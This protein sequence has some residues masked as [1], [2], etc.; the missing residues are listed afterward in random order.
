MAGR[1]PTAS[2]GPPWLRATSVGSVPR[3]APRVSGWTDDAAIRPAV[4]GPSAAAPP[5]PSVAR[6][7]NSAMVGAQAGPVPHDSPWPR[8]GPGRGVRHRDWPEDP[9]GSPIR[10]LH[11]SLD[12]RNVRP[13]STRSRPPSIPAGPGCRRARP[14]QR[15]AAHRR[16]GPSPGRAPPSNGQDQDHRPRGRTVPRRCRRC[17]PIADVA[18]HAAGDRSRS[19][20]DRGHCG[21]PRPSSAGSMP[22]CS[23]PS[24]ERSPRRRSALLG[25]GT[26]DR[27]PAP[28]SCSGKMAGPRRGF[29]PVPER[30]LRSPDRPS[31]TKTDPDRSGLQ[32]RHT[33]E[34]S[35]RGAARAGCRPELPPEELAQC[36]VERDAT[37][38]QKDDDQGKGGEREVEL[39]ARAR[40]SPR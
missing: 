20:I 31:P 30:P 38:A 16:V 22:R 10:P 21:P 29:Q 12:P 15:A 27:P 24:I 39:I 14:S 36:S 19:P 26:P 6:Q 25:G 33:S 34:R 37:R 13:P 11:H 35:T 32:E 40:A 2:T 8:A 28:S 9:G 4:P 1:N 17:P 7:S 23:D 5:A 18:R 3:R